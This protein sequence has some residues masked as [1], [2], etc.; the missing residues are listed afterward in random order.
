MQPFVIHYGFIL[1]WMWCMWSYCLISSLYVEV[2]VKCFWENIFNIFHFVVCQMFLCNKREARIVLVLLLSMYSFGMMLL[3][4]VCFEMTF[5]IIHSSFFIIFFSLT[6][7]VRENYAN[8][9]VIVSIFGIIHCC[10]WPHVTFS[11]VYSPTPT[12][13]ALVCW[14]KWLW[15]IRGRGWDCLY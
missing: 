9:T 14:C 8:V 7:L 10:W 5:C 4:L 15:R 12:P 2:R 6:A 11:F 3:L 13:T 1:N